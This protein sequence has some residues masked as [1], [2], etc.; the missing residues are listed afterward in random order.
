MTKA[1]AALTRRLMLAHDALNIIAN[2]PMGMENT[3]EYMRD[4]AREVFAKDEAAA[5]GL[6]YGQVKA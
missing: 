5:A 6:I 4:K 2:H 3:A 1:E